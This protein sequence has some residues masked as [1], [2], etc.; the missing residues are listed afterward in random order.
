MPR[1]L[2]GRTL[3]IPIR[4][5]ALFLLVLTGCAHED[6]FPTG[7][8]P[9]LGPRT[10]GLPRRLTY[11]IT[12]D[13]TPA[14]LPDGSA[15]VYSFVRDTSGDR[16]LGVLPAL[17]GT[18]THEKCLLRDFPG[19]T[20]ETLIWPAP[21]PDGRTA[22]WVDLRRYHSHLSPDRGAI[23]VGDLA[24]RDTGRVVRTIP[25]LAPSGNLHLLATHIGWL[26]P[27]RLVY[28]GSDVLYPNTTVVGLEVVLL[29]FSSSPATLTIVPNTGGATSVVPAAD[30]QSIYYTIAG[31]TEVFHQ[32]LATGA[33]TPVFDFAGAG[34]PSD[35]SLEGQRLT[36]VVD[37]QSPGEILRLDLNTAAL[38][39]VPV[40]AGP[41]ESARLS[42]DTRWIVSQV[43]D[44]LGPA[45]NK[46][47]W[48]L[49]TP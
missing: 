11:A 46:N 30:S 7:S 26:G 1:S 33:V 35:L 47:L 40:R 9:D 41:V 43:I 6:P 22:A 20:V 23:R 29:D 28:V 16:C 19:D 2:P 48:L 42:P 39:P 49:A 25:Y 4:S 10:P 37:R 34:E 5:G 24:S 36:V 27:T 8:P 21:G 12:D 38:L 14:W 44:T 13:I 32:I 31:S 18:R 45:P 3:P 15:L 17:G